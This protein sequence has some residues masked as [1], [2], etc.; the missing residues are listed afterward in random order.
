MQMRVNSWQL[1]SVSH[2]KIK[3]QNK[4]VSLCFTVWIHICGGKYLC[5]IFS[6]LFS[7]DKHA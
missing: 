1:C 5:F 7:L 6:G 2:I 4:P 3:P